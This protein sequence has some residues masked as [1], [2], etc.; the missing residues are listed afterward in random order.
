MAELRIRLSL[1]GFTTGLT[2]DYQPTTK[3]AIS[4]VDVRMRRRRYRSPI[5]IEPPILRYGW[6]PSPP[7]GAPLNRLHRALAARVGRSGAATTRRIPQ[8]F[9]LNLLEDDG[10]TTRISFTDIPGNRGL[11]AI[12]KQFPDPAEFQCMGFRPM[13]VSQILKE[14]KL[15]KMGSIRDGQ[16]GQIEIHQ[17]VINAL[18]L[19]PFRTES[20][21]QK[22]GQL[23]D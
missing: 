10:S 18:A 4:L 22:A 15:R 23:Y 16:D 8:Q 7:A 1:V 19:A 20:N 2:P 12:K 21:R 3:A 11:L 13:T 17:A 9:G 5:V 14:P 6:V